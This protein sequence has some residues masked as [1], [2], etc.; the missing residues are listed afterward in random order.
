MK[1]LDCKSYHLLLPHRSMM[2]QQ[3]TQRSRHPIR[4][5]LTLLYTSKLNNF[6]LYANITFSLS[7]H[8][9]RSRSLQPLVLHTCA[10]FLL[11]F[12]FLSPCTDGK[13]H[14]TDTSQRPMERN[15]LSQPQS[16]VSLMSKPLE[17]SLR[18]LFIYSHVFRNAY[19]CLWGAA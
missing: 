16:L 3:K 4:H 12:F 14:P 13:H 15:L 6:I 7:S 9:R 10:P 19:S 11:S 2:L 17:H 5:T 18:Q 1:L 8:L